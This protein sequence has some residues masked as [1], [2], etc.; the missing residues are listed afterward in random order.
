M[1]TTIMHCLNSRDLKREQYMRH[2]VFCV[3]IGKTTLAYNNS[4]KTAPP[5]KKS[6]A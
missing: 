3:K 2:K 1:T 4:E 5:K 6:P